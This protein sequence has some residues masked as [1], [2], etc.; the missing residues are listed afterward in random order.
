[1]HTSDTQDVDETGT[2]ARPPRP[3]V[4]QRVRLG[5]EARDRRRR[6]ARWTLLAISTVL[7][8]NALIGEKG[9]LA[10][11]R[12]QKE[13]ARIEAQLRQLRANNAR[14]QDDARRLRED[15][16][17]LEAV[18]REALGLVKPGETLIT[19]RDRPRQEP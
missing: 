2:P 13:E 15:P 4:R 11:V 16:A 3:R 5:S 8:V 17:A 7:M 6:I 1:M 14:L 9:Y 18:A 19:L 12:A 10:T